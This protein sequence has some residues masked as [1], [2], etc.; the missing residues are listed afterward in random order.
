MSEELKN[1]TSQIIAD[2]TKSDFKKALQAHK[3]F[4]LQGKNVEGSVLAALHFVIEDDTLILETTDGDRALI[5]KLNIITHE[6]NNCEFD[7]SMSLCSKLSLIKGELNQIRIVFDGNN[8]Q[9]IDV[10]YNTSFTLEIPDYCGMFPELSVAIPKK[11]NFTVKISQKLIK[12]IAS[13]HAQHGAIDMSINPKSKTAA[14]LFE[15][16]S[17]DF[18]QRAILMPLVDRTDIE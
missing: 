9:F 12:D 4:A 1:E 17:E 11:N 2:V 5:S 6:G 7:L 18:S 15:T 10:E 8:V 13:M 3:K 14:I 16:Q